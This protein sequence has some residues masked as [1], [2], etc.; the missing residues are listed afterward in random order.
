MIPEHKDKFVAP[1]LLALRSSEVRHNKKGP[2]RKRVIHHTTPPPP[3]TTTTTTTAWIEYTP[4]AVTAEDSIPVYTNR[5]TG[6][7]QQPVMSNQ[8]WKPT[9]GSGIRAIAA[10]KVIQGQ[11]R[12]YSLDSSNDDNSRTGMQKGT[13]TTTRGDGNAATTTVIQQW[14]RRLI[15]EVAARH[16][17][18]TTNNILPSVSSDDSSVN[19]RPQGGDTQGVYG[20]PSSSQKDEKIDNTIATSVMA[21]GLASTRPGASNG[22]SGNS[23][24]MSRMNGNRDK[25]PTLSDTQKR[26]V[27]DRLK[28]VL[29]DKQGR[30]NEDSPGVEVLDR[31]VPYVASEKGNGRLV[32]MGEGKGRRR[33]GK[34]EGKDD[35]RPRPTLCKENRRQAGVV[36]TAVDG[37]DDARSPTVDGSR[38]EKEVSLRIPQRTIRKGISRE[39]VMRIVWDELQ[40]VVEKRGKVSLTRVTQVRKAAA[41]AARQ[42]CDDDMHDSGDGVSGRLDGRHHHHRHRQPSVYSTLRIDT[43]K[44]HF[45]L[46]STGTATR[47]LLPEDTPDRKDDRKVDGVLRIPGCGIKRGISMS[48]AMSTARLHLET[49]MPGVMVHVKHIQPN[50]NDY[51]NATTPDDDGIREQYH[52][53]AVKGH[54]H[55]QEHAQSKAERIRV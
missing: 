20:L 26:A 38:M 24:K 50:G 13:P 18:N 9:H 48:K 15:M 55:D 4:N 31:P 34:E 43:D 40:R 25:R 47:V 17:T 19:D 30:D 27:V 16:Q 44:Q 45:I 10:A 5:D 29:D 49:A 51:T 7:Q 54:S 36:G 8:S 37:D 6:S 41:E 1:R 3:T 46:C 22:K 23:Y 33:I 32:K 39:E 35:N 42:Q 11:W 2:T 21:K 52:S 28:R 12:R 14:L 53:R